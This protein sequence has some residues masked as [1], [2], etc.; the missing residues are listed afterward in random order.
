MVRNIFIIGALVSEHA[1]IPE[2]FSEMKGI[3]YLV[4]K[5]KVI[6]VKRLNGGTNTCFPKKSVELHKD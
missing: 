6:V 1:L 5:G 3:F 4:K 2:S